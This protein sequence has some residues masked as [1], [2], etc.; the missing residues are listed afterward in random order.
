MLTSKMIF[1]QG[2]NRQSSGKRKGRALPL[3]P[4]AVFLGKHLH[5]SI[6]VYRFTFYG[7]N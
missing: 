6:F 5:V 7:Q 2:Q 3:R 4:E 1:M